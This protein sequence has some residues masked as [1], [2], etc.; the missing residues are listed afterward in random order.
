MS[1]QIKL[2]IFEGPMDLLLHL[3]KKHE[4][5]IYSIPIALITQQYLEY[6]DL[7]KSLDMEIAGDFLVMAS[8]L[9]H[10]KSRM[11]LPPAENPEGDEDGVDPRAELIRRLLEYKSFKE[12]AGSLGDKE[13]TWSQVYTRQAE[14]APDLPADDEPLLFD[15]HLFDLLAALKDIMARVPDAKFEITA[16]TVS[17]TEKISHILARLETTDS[18]LFVEL[19]ENSTTRLQVIGTFLALLELI[20][21]RVVKAFQIEQFGAIRIMKAVTDTQNRDQDT[22]TG[23]LFG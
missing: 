11:L 15:F 1:Y 2:E 16:E 4:L 9:T 18:L 22:A 12:A 23:N 20:K 21:T 5:D 19:F 7:M 8:T 14:A 6:I 17:I 13:E 10:I 3:I